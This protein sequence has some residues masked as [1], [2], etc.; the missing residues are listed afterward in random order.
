MSML[1]EEAVNDDVGIP[2]DSESSQYEINQSGKGL[3][4]KKNQN[5]ER[6][7]EKESL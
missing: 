5:S 4:K 1:E 7:P 3:L 6:R 2:G